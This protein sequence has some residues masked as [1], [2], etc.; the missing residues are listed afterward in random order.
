VATRHFPII[1]TWRDRL[2]GIPP[3]RI[4][5]IFGIGLVGTILIASAATLWYLRMVALADAE[6]R[7]VTL[8]VVLAEQLSRAVEAVDVVLVTAMEK[9]Q[10]AEHEAA[11]S[12]RPV[13]GQAI[14]NMFLTQF[15]GMPQ[16]RAMFAVNVQ[17]RIIYDSRVFPVPE[18]D[19]TD[20]AYFQAHRDGAAPGLYVSEPLRARV[21]NLPG[22]SVSRRLTDANGNFAGLIAGTI[23]PRYFQSFYESMDL[24]SGSVIRLYRHDGKLL[25]SYPVAG[26]AGED[27]ADAAAL[28]AGKDRDV[29]WRWDPQERDW[30]LTSLQFLGRYPLVVGVSTTESAALAGWR[31]QAAIFGAGGLAGAIVIALLL[32][33]LSRQFVRYETLTEAWRRS[34]E[35]FRNIAEASSDWIWEV[36][37]DLKFTYVS[38]RLYETTGVRPEEVL[39]RTREQL[40]GEDTENAAWRAYQEDL[41]ERRPLREFTYA[42]RRLDGSV[43]RFRIRG[44]PVYDESGHFRGYRG[45]GTDVT[46]EFEA[47]ERAQLAQQRLADAVEFLP[48]GFVLYD[49]EDR[50]VMSN[51]RYRAIH[52]RTPEAWTPGW[53]FEEILR[54]TFKSG[55]G[56]A[57]GGDIEMYIKRRLE[58]H[59]RD[60]TPPFEIHSEDRVLRV[61]ERRTSDGGV[62]GLHSDVS[63][64]R[65][66][67]AALLEAKQ[68]AEIANRAKSEFLANMSHELRTPLNAII[69]FAE[70]IENRVF[71][72]SSTRYHEYAH[73]I[74]TSGEHLLAVIN[75]ILDMSKIEAGRQDFVEGEVVMVDVIIACLAMV[76]RRA[77]YGGVQL[78][79][80]EPL[81]DLS[82]RADRRAVMQVL[83]NLL[84]NAVKF[85]P[86]DGSVRIRVEAGPT[87]AVL[88]VED[89]GAGIPEEALPHVFEPFRRGSAQIS[90]KSEGTGLGLP[91]SKRLMEQHG[92][93]LEL[94]STP[95]AGTCA[96]ATF[97]AQRVMRVG[98]SPVWITP[99]P[100]QERRA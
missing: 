13:N 65:R 45:T 40:A 96:R 78:I 10:T 9:L 26:A 47:E 8:D 12:G 19:V 22:F 68:A 64:A 7:L 70:V 90:H 33:G 21:D 58:Q 92:G 27:L 89:T 18:V 63:D 50:I 31:R 2:A 6:R 36:G 81:P 17:G 69:G 46:A 100:P 24:G 97:P 73:D 86:R 75:D 4:V 52:A 99:P 56:T 1:Q 62:V 74:R 39:G 76:K 79:V 77:E 20:R 43:R 66:R 49:A 51:S 87:G 14:R 38:G 48:D 83:L 91:I 88:T 82:L 54:A 60:L 59:L 30:S 35:R 34:E 23:E 84:S 29:S 42:H 71:G 57:P 25:A 41:D 28:D 44:S 93:S 55:E 11:T 67:E 72:P 61:A 80:Q 15:S 3:S 98:T 95:G 16:I 5:S 85:T 53:K 32:F 94:T 37:P